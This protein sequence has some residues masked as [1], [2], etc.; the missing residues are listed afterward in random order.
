MNVTLITRCREPLEAI[1]ASRTWMVNA[2]ATMQGNMSLHLFCN[3]I[4]MDQEIII[5][6]LTKIQHDDMMNT[7]S[8]NVWSKSVAA[9]ATSPDALDDS[10]RALADLK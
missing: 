5:E 10:I 3:I 7:G 8:R 4:K 6:K 2:L 1:P 9:M